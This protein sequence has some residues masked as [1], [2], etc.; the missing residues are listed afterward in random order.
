MRSSLHTSHR[1]TGRFAPGRFAPGR[2]APGRFAPGRFAHTDS[3]HGQFAPRTTRPFY[4]R[5]IRPADDSPPLRMDNSPHGRFA[6][7][8]GWTTRPLY[9]PHKYEQITLHSNVYMVL[10]RP[11]LIFQNS[12]PDCHFLFVFFFVFL[13]WDVHF[14]Y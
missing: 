2:L 14:R 8:I 10:I 12:I 5:T 13:R 4:W 6:L 3:P 9:F 1:V 11:L 7:Y